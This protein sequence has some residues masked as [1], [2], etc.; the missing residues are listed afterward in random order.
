MVIEKAWAK[1]FGSYERTD[2]GMTERTVMSLCG[3][4][5]ET[6]LH[7]GAQNWDEIWQ[8]LR[9]YDDKNYMIG[10]CIFKEG[11]GDT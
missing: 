9:E 5:Y 10:A 7:G 8:K 6:I 3:A 1:L 2:G 4:P 11:H